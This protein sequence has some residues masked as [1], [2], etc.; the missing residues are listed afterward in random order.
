M[1]PVS[2]S[3]FDSRSYQA[4]GDPRTA[5]DLAFADPRR[6]GLEGA[7][8]G[9]GSPE[10]PGGCFGP[11]NNSYGIRVSPIMQKGYVC[12][13]KRAR[14]SASARTGTSWG[15]VRARARA[16]ERFGHD[17][18]RRPARHKVH[19]LSAPRKCARTWLGVGEG[20]RSGCNSGCARTRGECERARAAGHLLCLPRP[21]HTAPQ[22]K[23]Q[24]VGG[25]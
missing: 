15:Q 22:A 16:H 23:L 14:C 6:L 2:A 20:A 3:G 9:R 10:S 17:R 7:E 19:S 12:K 18:R 1:D 11:C 5:P 24:N 21:Q 8:T 4:S 25:L 13:G